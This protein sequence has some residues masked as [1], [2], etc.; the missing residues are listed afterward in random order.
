M[1]DRRTFLG[2]LLVGAGLSPLLAS[3]RARGAEGSKGVAG[4]AGAGG[5][6][7]AAGE[8]PPRLTLS[9]ETSMFGR[10]G[11]PEAFEMVR[12]AG[13]RFVELGG[14]HFP[15]AEAS[16]E[17]IAALRRQL[18]G[19]G[20]TPVA[21]FVVHGTASAD[22]ARRKEAV[23]RWRRSLGAAQELGLKLLATELTGD[24]ADPA[25]GEAAFRRSLDEI[26]PLLEK[27][28]VHLSVEPHPGDFFEAAAP[29]LRLLG[30]Y[31]SKHLGYLHCTPHTFF[32]GRSSHEVI[33]EAGRLVTHVHVADT[34]RT[35]RIMARSGVGLHL[36]LRPGLGE[37]DFREVFDALGSIGYGAHVSVQLLSHAESPREAALES[38][39]HLQGLLGDRLVT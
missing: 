33:A 8:A 34:F 17:A 38:R 7:Q 28:G 5:A 1:I 13:F 37:V 25:A 10:Y 29:T 31:R 24:R 27:A 19:A 15:A 4:A 21:A 26:L 30:S 2:S 23:E 36:H 20:L 14:A 12:E 18:G 35:E 9:V 6:G 16:P 39:K 22:E 3:R 32:L 11:T